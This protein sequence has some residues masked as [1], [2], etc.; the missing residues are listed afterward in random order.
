M[1]SGHAWAESRDSGTTWHY[2]SCGLERMPYLYGLAVNSGDPDDIRIA[3]SPNPRT[4]HVDGLSSI[5]RYAG[6]TWVDDA[7]GFPRAH[8]LIPVLAADSVQAGGW[9]ALSNL[10]FFQKKQGATAWQAVIK[11]PAWNTMHPT[12]L[13]QLA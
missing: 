10:G 1:Q 3:A 4:A 6:G 5:Y 9:Y 13:V 11:L 2:T 7:E 12:C 8:S